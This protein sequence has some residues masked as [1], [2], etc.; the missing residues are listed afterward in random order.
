MLFKSAA[1]TGLVAS[2]TAMM[3][4]LTP[5]PTEEDMAMFEA[6]SELEANYTLASFADTAS[7]A[8]TYIDTYVHVVASSQSASD[9]YLGV[10]KAASCLLLQFHAGLIKY[11]RERL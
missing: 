6:I 8:T 9:G 11:F 3:P 7:E 1:V 4:C 10:S 2:A 5:P